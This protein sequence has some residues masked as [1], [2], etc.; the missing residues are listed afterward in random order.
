MCRE[1]LVVGQHVPV[2][3]SEGHCLY[4]A[5]GFKVREH[6]FGIVCGESG[7]AHKVADHHFR[8][9]FD[10]FCERGALPGVEVRPFHGLDVV[11]Q[12]QDADAL[13]VDNLD[14]AALAQFMQQTRVDAQGAHDL[15]GRGVCCCPDVLDESPYVV[16]PEDSFAARDGVVVQASFDDDARVTQL[17]E[18]GT[19]G[20]DGH[21]GTLDNFGRCETAFRGR[22]EDGLDICGRTLPGHVNMLPFP[23]R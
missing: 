6:D 7:D 19:D 4:D 18:G 15:F 10:V 16:A 13:A 23:R 12:L 21:S 8:F 3:V 1:S 2:G 9:V 22:Q 17:L 11:T 5:S 20:P 14:V